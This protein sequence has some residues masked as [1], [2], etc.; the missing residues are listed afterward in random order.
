V[1]WTVQLQCT[2]TIPID[3]RDVTNTWQ[4]QKPSR[5]QCRYFEDCQSIVGFVPAF[6]YPEY[7]PSRSASDDAQAHAPV[8]N[9]TDSRLAICSKI[10]LDSLQAAL[11]SMQL[12]LGRDAVA[13]SSNSERKVTFN[14]AAAVDRQKVF[15]YQVSLPH[16]R[17]PHFLETSV[18]R[19]A[20]MR[21]TVS[22]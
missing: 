10:D 9:F 20:S 22:Q 11:S 1:T 6:E 16:Y 2:C 15:Y 21:Y 18:E 12:S 4:G 5:K 8:S 7:P 13:A 19:H 17:D 14:L 3:G